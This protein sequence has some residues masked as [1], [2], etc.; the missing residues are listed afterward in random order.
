MPTAVI[1]HIIVLLFPNRERKAFNDTYLPG[2]LSYSVFIY[3]LQIVLRKKKTI[4]KN[5]SYQKSTVASTIVNLF[6]WVTNNIYHETYYPTLR[7]GNNIGY[8]NWKS[9]RINQRK[10]FLHLWLLKSC[11]NF[12]SNSFMYFVYRIASI[13]KP[14]RELKWLIYIFNTLSDESL[15]HG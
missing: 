1:K 12:L 14:F 3:F 10:L 7:Q 5:Q 2:R 15:L 8:G 6:W 13:S 11:Y 4:V 9:W